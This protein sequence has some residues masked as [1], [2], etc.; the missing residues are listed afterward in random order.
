MGKKD[1]AINYMNVYEFW[2]TERFFDQVTRD[3]LERLADQKEIEDRFYCDLEFGTGGLRGVMG[4]GTNRMNHYTVGKAT[5]GLGRYLLDTYG[6]KACEKRGVAIGYD[7]RNNSHSF[8]QT[9]ANVLSGMGIRVYLHSSA[10]PTPQLSFSVKRWNALAGVVITASHNPKEYNGYKVYDEFGC[11]LVPW[12][13]KQ[14]I[15]YIDAISDYRTINFK[16]NK[17]LIETTDVTDEFVAAVMKQSRYT[18]A[19]AKADLKVVYT[20]L[21]GTGNVPVRK[22]L[23]LDGFDRVELVAEQIEGNG[24]FP[25]VVSPN[26]EDRRALQMGIAQAERTRGDIVLGTDPDSDRVGVAVKTEN[27]YQLMTGNQIGALLMDFVLD[28]TDLSAYKNPAVVKTVV[29]SELG[30]E[31]ARKKGLTVFSTLT[32]FKFIGEKI[33]QFEQARKDKDASREYDFV[34][35]YEESYGYLAGTHARDKDAVVSGLLICE[36]AAKLK[37]EGKT[38]AD[39]MDELYVEFG[40]YRDELESFTLKGKDGL[41]KISSMMVDLRSGASPFARTKQVVD[42]NRPVQAE[43]GFG[44]LPVSNVLKY[45]LEDG[46]WIAVRPSGTEPKIKIYYSIKGADKTEAEQKLKDIRTVITTR[47]GL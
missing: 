19:E 6:T 20:P 47:L 46:S 5:M 7:T 21:H 2:K 28:N 32:G 9:T 1:A 24:D 3:E 41:E 23:Q 15:T 44:V 27:G 16:G 14:V 22:M 8:A 45:I 38:L 12:Q 42:Y 36:L 10:R 31:I 39:R 13:A 40:Y 37:A 11:Q 30:A 29:T 35:G 43:P 18:N 26:P 17:A 34:L 4:A 25:T 33:T